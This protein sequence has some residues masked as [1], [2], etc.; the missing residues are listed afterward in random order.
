MNQFRGWEAVAKRL[1]TLS[2][3]HEYLNEG[4]R[5]N[6][7]AISKRLPEHG[8]IL[9]DEVGMGK[10]R[11]AVTIARA[12]RECGGRTAIVVPPGLANQW[13]REL[14]QGDAAPE[15]PPLRGIWQFLQKWGET[16][17]GTNPWSNHSIQIISQN[18]ANWRNTSRIEDELACQNLVLASLQSIWI[19]EKEGKHR[20]GSKAYHPDASSEWEGDWYHYSL[21]AAR[22]IFSTTPH[23]LLGKLL[24]T[25]ENENL[26]SQDS[27]VKHLPAR[28]GLHRAIG[29]G[30]GRFD[31]VVID[32]AHKSRGHYGN[33]SSLLSQIL[34]SADHSRRLAMTATP[35]ELDLSQW[36]QS[37]ERID[38][39]RSTIEQNLM[40]VIDAYRE[41]VDLLRLQWRTNELVREEYA[42]AA[43]NFEAALRPYLLRRSKREDEKV[44]EFARISGDQHMDYR[45]VDPVRVKFGELS[46]EWKQAVVAAEALSCIRGTDLRTKRLRLTIGHGNGIADTLNRVTAGR[47]DRSQLQEDG[48]EFNH[49]ELADGLLTSQAD[50]K[51]RDRT[52]FWTNMI[53]KASRTGGN[54]IVGHPAIV[55]IA[56]EIESIDQNEKILVF[57]RFIEPM[58]AL[59]ARLNGIALIRCVA[60]GQ[61]WPRAKLGDDDREV[62]KILGQ[63]DAKISNIEKTIAKGMLEFENRRD[64]IIRRLIDK[65]FQAEFSAKNSNL[66]SLLGIALERGDT[67]ER[68]LLARA[69]AEALPANGQGLEQELMNALEDVLL[70]LASFDENQEEVAS[71]IDVNSID[72]RNNLDDMRASWESIHRELA[73]E[74]GEGE[75]STPRSAYARV[76]R[77]ATPMQ[78]RKL[79]Q[80]A[81]NN[82]ARYPRV[83]IAQ[84]MVGREGLNLHE[85]CRTVVMLHLEWNPGVVEQQ[86]GRVDRVNSLWGEKLDDY[87]AKPDGEL[88]RISVRPVIFEGTYDQHHWDVLSRRW[89][90][91]RAQLH[92]EA[93]PPSERTGLSLSE[94]E[95]LTYLDEA[96]PNFSPISSN[97]V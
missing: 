70:P 29:F 30:L 33:L 11:I 21:N 87:A 28:I 19:K 9:A 31:L 84:S 16:S 10:T 4:Q 23:K 43:Q 80:G 41:S 26:R 79:L 15:S 44:K 2:E 3:D 59:A 58:L 52:D 68:S 61:Y 81:F 53:K 37:F 27:Y 24:R 54:A 60:E 57:G 67:K 64:A 83:L 20:G 7:L 95:A 51:I 55:A 18:F 76:M 72:Q 50:L 56:N 12:V 8:L 35:V 66:A 89:L 94:R 63:T 86:I 71:G 38:L 91:L 75:S 78:T 65:K 32:E 22:S 17:E 62:L 88:P 34:W 45:I 93:I 13:I 46:T 42:K 90:D 40:P 47:D 85:T 77:G 73:E 48:V 49:T 6:I 92:G 97:E 96:A 1:I 82:V 39:P 5:A 69:V 14:H 74:Y 36:Q 25:V